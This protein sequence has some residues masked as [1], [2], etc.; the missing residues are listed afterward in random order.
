M[1]VILPVPLPAGWGLSSFGLFSYGMGPPGSLY[2]VGAYPL[3]ERTLRVFLSVKAKADSTIDAGDALNPKTWTVTRDDTGAQLLVLAVARVDDTT[4]DLYMLDKLQPSLIE[5]TVET[6]T[7]L[8][9][10][11]G[12]I[13]APT[14]VPFVGCSYAAPARS[15][16]ALVDLRNVPNNETDIGGIYEVGSDGDYVT[17]SGAEFLK[18]LIIRRLV[19]LPGEFF[20]LTEYGIGFRVKEPLPGNDLVQLAAAIELQLLKEPEF[21]KVGVGLALSGDNV[22]TIQVAAVLRR[23]NEQVVIPITV[24]GALVSL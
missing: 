16:V 8:A 5:H 1:P 9:A 2:L 19:T 15:P 3:S 4:F 11:G 13:V 24:P 7:L 23:S 21:S 17:H 10:T 12:L 18:K 6:T 14:D 20:F 22:L